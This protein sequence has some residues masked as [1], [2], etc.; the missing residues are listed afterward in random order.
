M[1]RKKRVHKSA[2]FT[3]VYAM[4]PR[5]LHEAGV[6]GVEWAVLVALAQHPQRNG[7]LSRPVSDYG[8]AQDGIAT[9][10]GCSPAQVRKALEALTKKTFTATDGTQTPILTRKVSA[11]RGKCAVFKCNLPMWSDHAPNDHEDTKKSVT[12]PVPINE[13]KG[14]QSGTSCVPNPVPHLE[15]TGGAGKEQP[16]PPWLR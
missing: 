5:L 13:E 12:N 1:P 3:K 11:H 4:W 6:S 14:N 10:T 15:K 8:A 7:F 2:P 9:A 16:T